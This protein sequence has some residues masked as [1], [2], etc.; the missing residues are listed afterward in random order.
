MPANDDFSVRI[1]I[2]AEERSCS[3]LS[4]QKTLT[5]HQSSRRAVVEEEIGQ[6]SIMLVL[7]EPARVGGDEV[8]STREFGVWQELGVVEALH[9]ESS[10]WQTGGSDVKQCQSQHED[11]RQRHGVYDY[12]NCYRKYSYTCDEVRE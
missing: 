9:E 7:G 3:G 10:T 6:V 2:I 8:V 1:L 11:P 4:Q 5:K 12:C